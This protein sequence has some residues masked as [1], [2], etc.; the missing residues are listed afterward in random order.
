ME[1][2]EQVLEQLTTNGEV[3]RKKYKD[4]HTF[5]CSTRWRTVYLVYI[6]YAL[7][8]IHRVNLSLAV[9]CIVDLDVEEGKNTN[10]RM[11][12]IV[13]AENRTSELIDDG[14]ET[15]N[16]IANAIDQNNTLWPVE[17]GRSSKNDIRRQFKTE[18]ENLTADATTMAL[19]KRNTC[20]SGNVKRKGPKSDIKWRKSLISILLSSYFYGSLFTQI[21]A[22][23][24]AD[25]FGGKHIMTGAMVL[26]AVCSFLVP[27]CA[28]TGIEWVFVLRILIGFA[29]GSVIPAGNSIIAAWGPPAE[30]P[31]MLAVVATGLLFGA[32]VSFLTSGLLCEHGFANGWPSIFYI[33][34]FLAVLFVIMWLFDGYS[35]PKH[36][37]RISK[38]ELEYIVE[39]K[40]L[41]ST[42][43]KSQGTP[44]K[45]ILTSRPMW[46]CFIT[47][48][49]FNW[50][51]FTVII[52]VPLFLKEV[53][54]YDI[55]SNGVYSALPYIFQIF[56]GLASGKISA[57]ILKKKCLSHLVTRRLFQTMCS[58]GCGVCLILAGYVT[59]E[60]RHIAVVLLCCSGI[61]GGMACA[62]F[63]V[64]HPEFSGQ[65][66]GTTFGITNAGGVVSSIL[67]SMI[68]GLLTPKGLQ[69]EWQ[70]VF[71][72]AAVVNF[73]GA[74]SFLFFSDVTLQPWAQGKQHT[75]EIEVDPPDTELKPMKA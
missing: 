43:N 25:I 71:Y 6:A 46:A 36:H 15:I 50:S 66:S 47:H 16:N 35:L 10:T 45:G 73:V 72:I 54:K 33:H 67:A 9:V 21:P 3:N 5:V 41:V 39:S 37:P 65:F 59:C 38:E 13:A 31:S 42:V 48:F 56:S 62:G 61:F 34:G 49:C 70:V 57:A 74:L 63:F 8:F 52:N 23:T 58:I 40:R 20:G 69:S 2:N 1:E 32:V 30:R 75:I 7:L 17:V 60:V 27:V 22:G 11:D 44:W 55:T 24:L 68:A 29:G 28:R 64:N 26:T 51:F 4:R 14:Y 12:N 19:V 18:D 53:L